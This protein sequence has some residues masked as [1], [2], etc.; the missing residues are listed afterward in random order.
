MMVTSTVSR[1]VLCD[2]HVLRWYFYGQSCQLPCASM[3][4][5]CACMLLRRLTVCVVRGSGDAI[6]CA[7]T[8]T[9]EA[10]LVG[11]GHVCKTLAA[12]SALER[13]A[14]LRQLLLKCI[15]S[16]SALDLTTMPSTRTATLRARAE[17]ASAAELPKALKFMHE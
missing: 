6:F 15:G 13:C 7:V 16:C 8:D 10:I 1:Q 11:C 2:V 3:S 9:D 17:T 5:T 14:R 4:L 12:S